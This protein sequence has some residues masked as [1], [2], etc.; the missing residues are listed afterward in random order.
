MLITNVNIK[1][2]DL[3]YKDLHKITFEFFRDAKYGLYLHITICF[4]ND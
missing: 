4:S 1:V 2:A 3:G